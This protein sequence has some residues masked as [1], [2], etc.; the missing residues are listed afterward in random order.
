MVDGVGI[1]V[2][3]LVATLPRA[4]RSGKRVNVR[5]LTDTRN[6]SGGWRVAPPLRN[7]L[8]KRKKGT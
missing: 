1:K 4:N 2:L 5:R 7:R 6:G 8:E 3:T